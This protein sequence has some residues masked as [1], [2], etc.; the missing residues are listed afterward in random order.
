MTLDYKGR[1]EICH[2]PVEGTSV[3]AYPVTGWEVQR[4]QGGQNHVIDRRRIPNR[5]AHW[6]CLEGK[7]NGQQL[8]F[9]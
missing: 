1:C 5:V 4:K 8:S 2:K 7:L 3:A 6:V 9:R